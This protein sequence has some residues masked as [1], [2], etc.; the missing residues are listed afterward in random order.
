MAKRG[1]SMPSMSLTNILLLLA[2]VLFVIFV[3]STMSKR[4]GLPE[5]RRNSSNMYQSTDQEPSPVMLGPRA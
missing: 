2:A 3:F 4:E 5:K 1:M